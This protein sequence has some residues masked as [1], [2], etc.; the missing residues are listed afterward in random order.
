MRTFATLATAAT[1]ALGAAASPLAG[2]G[3]APDPGHERV[4][5]IRID[6]VRYDPA[7]SD[8]G[9]N[10]HV[11]KEVVQIKNTTGQPRRMKGWTLRDKTGHRYTFPKTTLKPGRTVTVHTGKGSDKPRQRYW[12]QGYYVWNNDGDKATLRTD[13]GRQIDACSWND[14]DGNTNC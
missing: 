4:G 11:N 5:S 9:S 2:A 12:D 7:G 10:G 3:A 1:L 13:D 14:G 8:N 6:F